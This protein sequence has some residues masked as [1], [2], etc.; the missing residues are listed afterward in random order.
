[1]E[2][3]SWRNRISSVSVAL[4]HRF[5]PQPQHSRLKDLA[6][7]VWVTTV[8]WI[9]SLTWELHMP[10]GGQKKK[11]GKKKKK[12]KK[13]FYITSEKCLSDQKLGELP[14]GGN[15]MLQ[16]L[17]FTLHLLVIKQ[18]SAGMRNEVPQTLKLNRMETLS[19]STGQDFSSLKKK[20]E[21]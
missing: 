17:N 21:A 8:A 10:Q 3:L 1:M 12:G 5:D 13:I 11:G 2:F 7:A 6:S 15:R 20:K 9:R 16:L 14:C 4:G 18:P 19:Y